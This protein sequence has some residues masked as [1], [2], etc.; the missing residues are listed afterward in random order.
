MDDGRV[1]RHDDI[2]N[3]IN[4]L[5][6]E[7]YKT[8]LSID[9]FGGGLA[10]T[11]HKVNTADAHL[12]E[13]DEEIEKRGIQIEALNAT[14]ETNTTA[15]AMIVA[16]L[17]REIA[18]QKQ[19]IEGQDQRIERLEEVENN[20]ELFQEVALEEEVRLNTTNQRMIPDVDQERRE[21]ELLTTRLDA[22]LEESGRHREQFEGVQRQLVGVQGQLNAANAR[23]DELSRNTTR[24]EADMARMQT[25]YNA[26]VIRRS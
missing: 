19:Q 25:E 21:N 23:N 12:A 20:F 9:K 18:E 14:I 11:Y 7:Q 15:H 10:E 1:G 3:G 8:V 4:D 5:T 13:K 17:M 26:L 16:D 24:I 2:R 6:E 22:A